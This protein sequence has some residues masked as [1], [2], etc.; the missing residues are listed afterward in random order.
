MKKYDVKKTH[1]DLYAPKSGEFTVVEVP[2][3]QYLA[4]DGRGDPNT[5][6]SYADAIE[7][8]FG[9]SYAV[10]FDSKNHLDR[11]YVVAPLQALWRAE[12]MAAFVRRDK[13]SWEWTVMI[14]QPDWIT[15]E[16]VVSGAELVS[17]KKDL[18]A[19]SD[20]R[21]MALTEGTSIQTLHIGSYDDEGPV[22][23]RLHHEYLPENDLTFN[24]D[25][26]EIYLSDARR[27]EPAKLKTILRQPVQRVED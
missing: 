20:L 23:E 6:S 12:E 2:R 25:H 3:F 17:S 11:D 18:A 8:L 5:S 27:T 4:V 7:A 10:K 22:L 19:L 1:K 9:V 24:G 26:H 21:L 14:N 13:E 16:M 15:D